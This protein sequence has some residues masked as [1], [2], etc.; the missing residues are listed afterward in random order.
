[1]FL[2]SGGGGER[3]EHSGR[4]YAEEGCQR[5]VSEISEPY[6]TAQI[7]NMKHNLIMPVDDVNLDVIE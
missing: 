7:V 2:H 3:K 5:V 1:M 4:S 6:M